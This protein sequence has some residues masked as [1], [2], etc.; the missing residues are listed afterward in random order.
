[1]DYDD[2]PIYFEIIL[3]WIGFVPTKGLGALKKASK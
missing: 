3:S 1:M 2:M